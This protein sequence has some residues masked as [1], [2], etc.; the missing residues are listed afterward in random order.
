MTVKEILVLS[1]TLSDRKDL[2]TYIVEGSSDIS[3]DT[4]LDAETLLK[5]YNITISEIA[6]EY[7]RLKTIEEFVAT[8]GFLE[9]ENL[10]ENPIAIVK[11]YDKKGEQVDAKI[12]P[13]KLYTNIESGL[14]EYEY[15]PKDQTQEEIC[16]FNGTQ[17]TG[18]VIA[19]G[20]VTQFLLI[21]GAY[22]EAE[23]FNGRYRASLLASLTPRQVKKIPPRKWV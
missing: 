2:A 1:A 14:V 4:S 20:I 3:P 10:K 12:L 17:I 7:Y 11:V 8:N 15:L 13:T 16:C 5:C 9:Y 18:R 6:T 23:N 21:K 22:N 19:L